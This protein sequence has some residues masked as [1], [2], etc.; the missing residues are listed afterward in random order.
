M[1]QA[2]SIFDIEIAFVEEPFVWD[3]EEFISGCEQCDEAAAIPFDY[4]L[5]ALTGCNPALTEYLMEQFAQC[6]RCLGAI[7]EKTLVKVDP[8]GDGESEK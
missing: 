6:P 4:L 3:A 2:I 8:A 1:R 7:T 5:D